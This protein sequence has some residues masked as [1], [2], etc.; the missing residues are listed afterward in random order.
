M[1]NE[2][3]MMAKIEANKKKNKNVKKSSFQKRMEE[4]AKQKG[5]KK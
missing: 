4:M 3:K 5:I 1:I 2:D